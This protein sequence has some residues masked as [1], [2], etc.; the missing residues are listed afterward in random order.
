MNDEEKPAGILIF[1]RA[2]LLELW[3]YFAYGL[4]AAIPSIW[5]LA[6]NRALPRVWIYLVMIPFGFPS[7]AFLVWKKER[8]ERNALAAKVTTLN[9]EVDRERNALVAEV[10]S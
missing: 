6:T 2:V 9:V 4:G 3:T 5:N 10:A 1:I 8:I 7:G